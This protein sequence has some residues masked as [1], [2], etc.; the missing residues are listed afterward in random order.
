MLL[1]GVV[2]IMVTAAVVTWGLTLVALMAPAIV[3][4]KAL[5]VTAVGVVVAIA[6][7]AVRCSLESEKEMVLSTHLM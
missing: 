1:R 5:V 7:E 4:L 2:R 6:V 3:L